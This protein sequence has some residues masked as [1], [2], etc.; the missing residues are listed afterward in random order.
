MPEFEVVVTIKCMA[1]AESADVLLADLRKKG[2][3]KDELSKIVQ[4]W[5]N[6][7]MDVK[8]DNT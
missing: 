8:C 6:N 1:E 5:M 7:R 2:E 3:R 4:A